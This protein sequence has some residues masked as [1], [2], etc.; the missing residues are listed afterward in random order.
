MNYPTGHI[1]KVQKFW[2]TGHK[3][4]K[5]TETGTGFG[6][7]THTWTDKLTV[8]GRFRKVRGTETMT[9]D[10]A[11]IDIDAVFYCFPNPE[12]TKDDRYVTRDGSEW[13]YIEFINDVM[14]MET[15]CQI[16]LKYGGKVTE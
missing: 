14:S 6:G 15:L 9:G 7:T 2:T 16:D 13:Y 11:R 8:E 3:I 1:N 10:Q 4:Q 12:I 5:W